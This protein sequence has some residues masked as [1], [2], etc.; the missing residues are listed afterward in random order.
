M[1]VLHIGAPKTGTTALQQFLSTNEAALRARG[2]SYMRAGRAHIAHNPLPTAIA[3]NRAEGML[4]A[5]M[6]EHDAAPDL[7]HVISS[8]IMFRIVVVQR[9][10]PVLPAGMRGAVRVLCYLRRQDHYLEAIY[11][12][13]VK[14]GLTPPDR[15]AF[16]EAQL[17]KLSF[18]RLI[19]GYADLFGPE[20]I[21]LRPFDRARLAGGDIVR[22]FAA[23]IGLTDLEGLEGVGAEANPSLSVELSEMLGRFAIAGSENV[24]TLIRLISEMDDPALFA[25]RDAYDLES[26]RRVVAATAADTE[27]M[28]ARYRPDLGHFFETAD[29]EAG[30]G[31][32][33]PDPVAAARRAQAGALAISRALS[34]LRSAPPDNT[35]PP[36]PADRPPAPPAPPTVP[37]PGGNAPL[38]FPGVPVWFEE[39]CPAGPREGFFVWLGNH[40][41]SFV[42]RGTDQLVVTFDNLHNVGDTRPERN[43][44]AARFCAERGWSHLG[45]I[46]QRPDWFRDAAL[47]GWLEARAA[48]GFFA[49]FA[50]VAFAG[51]SMGGFGALVFSALAPGA[52]VAAFSPQ[53]TLARRLVRWEGRFAKGR[54]ADWTLP[55][56]DAAEAVRHAGRVWVVVDPFEGNDMRHAARLG[57]GPVTVLRAPGCGHKTALALNRM[58]A[59]KEVLGGAIDGTLDPAGFARRMRGRRDLLLW[60]RTLAERLEGRGQ[61][62]RAER[63]RRLYRARRGAAAAAEAPTTDFPDE[64]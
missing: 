14:N 33:A 28:R 61:S 59:L 25:S 5:I 38:T 21:R 52:T 45:V 64:D 47:I 62:A 44:W 15:A 34:L 19:D 10:R 30:H 36:A 32:H 51:A 2:I 54:G 46:S 40:G 48:E 60:C 1:I 22:D 24:R 4:R 53:S 55:H 26:R 18:G 11:K 43:P 23:E 9:L 17:P 29:L 8:E 41:A 3:Q 27:A 39:I 57:A 37:T 20:A 31:A 49:R 12:Q 7:L 35:P 16:L 13:R 50:R 58:G 63:L 6:D 56:G 42:D